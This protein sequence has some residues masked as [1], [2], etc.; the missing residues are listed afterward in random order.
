[1]EPKVGIKGL[2]EF[3]RGLKKIDSEAPKQLRV[4][5][6]SGSDLLINKT[7][8]KIPSRSGKARASLKARSTRTSVRIAVGGKMAPYVPWLDYGGEGRIRGRPAPREFIKAGRYLYPTLGEIRPA[9]IRTL[10]EAIRDVARNAGL[11]V[12]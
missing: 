1:M 9:L 10:D 6:N 7:R 3:S 12:D 8:P 5:L 2:A 11:E 4:A